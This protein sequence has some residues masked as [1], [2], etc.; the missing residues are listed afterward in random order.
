[1]LSSIAYK[2]LSDDDHVDKT[3]SMIVQVTDDD[4]MRTECSDKK[5]GSGVESNGSDG[6]DAEGSGSESSG[7]EMSSDVRKKEKDNMTTALLG[8]EEN[9]SCIDSG[10]EDLNVSELN[11]LA[12]SLSDIRSYCQTWEEAS[13]N[14]ISI[15]SCYH[16][17]TLNKMNIHDE[18]NIIQKRTQ[19]RSCFSF[20]R[21]I[22]SMF[23]FN[24][25]NK[26]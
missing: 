17:E 23:H 26:K 14:T 18:E 22:F 2:T 25:K 7:V 1:M 11:H 24:K 15:P 13:K 12:S 3:S 5:G 8:N 10:N 21:F 19:D 4:D 6:S 20:L 16:D 9:S